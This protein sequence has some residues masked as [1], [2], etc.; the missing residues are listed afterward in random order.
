[1][2]EFLLDYQIV[3]PYNPLE[4]I[5][6]RE[7]ICKKS[8]LPLTLL[9]V[10]PPKNTKETIYRIKEQVERADVRKSDNSRFGTT[11]AK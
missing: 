8:R 11:S 5:A 4:L 10:Q 1:V 3:S 2:T 6:I 7:A 9:R